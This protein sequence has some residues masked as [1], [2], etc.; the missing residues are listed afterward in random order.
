M[1]VS[2]TIPCTHEEIGSVL[3]FE[4]YAEVLLVLFFLVMTGHFASHLV[5]NRFGLGVQCSYSLFT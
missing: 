4:Y 3:L 5:G 1:M 2:Q